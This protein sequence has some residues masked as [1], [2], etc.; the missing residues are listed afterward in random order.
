MYDKWTTLNLLNMYYIHKLTAVASHTTF[1]FTFWP[2]YILFAIA[3]HQPI[4][5]TI[6]ELERCDN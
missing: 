4:D 3:G 2:S 1:F 5:N 6:V